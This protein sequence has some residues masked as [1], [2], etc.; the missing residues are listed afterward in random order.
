MTETERVENKSSLTELRGIVESVA[1][2]ASASGGTIRV[3]VTPDGTRVG[4]SLGENT[5]ENLANDIKRNTDPPQYPSMTWDASE[6]SA[7]ISISVAESPL[8]PVM[9]FNRPMKRVG[10]TNQRLSREEAHRLMDLS[11][12][13]SWDTLRCG[14]FGEEDVDQQAVGRF[15][16]ECGSSPDQSFTNVLANLGLGKGGTVG[17]GAVLLF[18]ANPQSFFPEAVV[19]CAR[20]AG[21]SSA[22][23]LDEQTL[24]GSLLAQLD[25]AMVFVRRN[26]QQRIVISGKP[27]HDVVPEYPEAAVREAIVNALCHRDYS[28]SGTVQVRIYDDRMEVWNPGTLPPDLSVEALYREHPSRPRNPYL[29]LALHRARLLERWGS[30]TLRI[31]EAMEQRSL[32]KPEFLVDMGTFI[33]RMRTR[34]SPED[35]QAGGL[36][37]ERQLQVLEY[38]RQHESISTKEYQSLFGLGRKQAQNDLAGLYERRVVTRE[39]RGPRTAYRLAEP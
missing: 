36:L 35:L 1:A 20:F 9:A 38:L 23:F 33:V 34:P 5:L 3:G 14:Y 12:G 27:A 19:K 6:G 39:G 2:F 31:V 30:G 22:Q 24:E 13:H 32:P 7:V 37:N 25:G 10:R 16:R 21:G 28:T 8:K 18:G 26:T 17:N 29:A 15:L 11:A 4:V